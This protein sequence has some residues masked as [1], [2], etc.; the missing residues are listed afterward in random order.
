MQMTSQIVTEKSPYTRLEEVLNGQL[1]R[2]INP[3]PQGVK[4]FVEVDY[5]PLYWQACLGGGRHRPE[6]TILP[7]SRN[8]FN[9]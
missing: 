1:S 6:A 4:A 2:S 9:I 8:P 7:L 3:R 5:C